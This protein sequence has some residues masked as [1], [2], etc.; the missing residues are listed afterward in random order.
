VKRVQATEAEENFDKWLDDSQAEPVTIQ[1]G[2]LDMAVMLSI[3]H[4]HS[5]T[6][7][8]EVGT[9]MRNSLDRSMKRWDEL[10]RALDN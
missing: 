9:D 10:Y 2:G 5:L 1:Q 8:S 7:N 6:K 4:F 3:E